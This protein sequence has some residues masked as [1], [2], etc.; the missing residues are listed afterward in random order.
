MEVLPTK[1][2]PASNISK[3]L[4]DCSTP[5]WEMQAK[6]ICPIFPFDNTATLVYTSNDISTRR[7]KFLIS[8]PIET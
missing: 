2:R 5:L 6:R 3:N 4:G 8:L 1:S 7:H